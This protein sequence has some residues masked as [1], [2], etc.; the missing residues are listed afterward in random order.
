MYAQSAT[1][2]SS[3]SSARSASAM[4]ESATTSA[5]SSARPLSSTA[6]TVGAMRSMNVPAPGL[7]PKR[8][9]VVEAKVSGPVVRSSVTS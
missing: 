2:R 3:F 5:T 7:A 9:T 8:T 6:C 1:T 4:R